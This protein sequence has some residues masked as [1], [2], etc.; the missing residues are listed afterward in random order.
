MSLRSPLGRARGLGSAKD[1]THHWWAQRLTAVALVPLLLWFV[2]SVAASTGAD[3]LAATAWLANPVTAVLMVLLIVAGLHH[4]QLGL[5]VVIEDYVHA[6]W[7]K[8]LS[9][10]GVR[11]AAV[12]LG[13]AAVF[14]ILK[15]ALGGSVSG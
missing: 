12:A 2:A 4:G 9:I 6:E 13:V 5:Q 1:G 8:V 14:S 7:V 15:I 10:M 11:L 3:H